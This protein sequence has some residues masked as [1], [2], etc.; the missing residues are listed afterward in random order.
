MENLFATPAPV[1]TLATQIRERLRAAPAHELRAWVA[2]CGSGEDAYVC[3]ILLH[4]AAARYAPGAAIKVFAT[5]TSQSALAVARRGVFP[6]ELRD[7]LPPAWQAHA[8]YKALLRELLQ[9]QERER[10]RI[11]RDLHDQFGQQITAILLGLRAAQNQIAAESPAVSPIEQVREQIQ[12]LGKEI[13]Q[14]ATDLRPTALDDVGLAEALQSYAERWSQQT[15][16]PATFFETG[17]RGSALP[18]EVETTVYRVAIEAL[19]NVARHTRASRINLILERHQSTL[20][21]MVEDNGQGFDVDSALA[22]SHT[23]EH[24]GLIGM[25]ERVALIDGT[26]TIESAPGGGTTVIS[27]IPLGD[28]RATQ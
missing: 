27:R 21:L 3:A 13:H 26:L 19:T 11:A 5:D 1:E 14:V 16:M 22:H 15:G 7:R 8:A 25:Y 20:I 6:A 17:V 4:A 2:G 18:K 12:A 23:G 28:G 24:I 9:T 10:L